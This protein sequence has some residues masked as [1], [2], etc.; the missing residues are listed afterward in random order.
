MDV[1]ILK[2][3]KPLVS[4]IIP[5]FN[6]KEIIKRAIESVIKQ[7]YENW[8]LIVVDDG[9]TD[10]T[11]DY[12]SKSI[13]VWQDNIEQISGYQKSIRTIQI[14]HRGVS[15]ARNFGIENSQGEWICFLD[16]DDEWL[17]EKLTCQI[18]FHSEHSDIEFSQTNEIWNKKGNLLSPKGKHK[19]MNGSY[20]KESL[21][22]CMVTNSS[23]MAKKKAWIEVGGYRNELLT[24][25]DY[26]V[27]NRI[28]I[29]GKEIGLIEKPLLIRYGGHQ[30]QLSLRY[31]AMERFRLYSLLKTREE[32]IMSGYW[33]DLSNAHRIL[34]EDAIESRFRI[35]IQG[36]EKRGKS[37]Q[38]LTKLQTL[39]HSGKK[40]TRLDLDPLISNE[41]SA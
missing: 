28:F 5:T 18:K 40:I 23:F 32:K 14:D 13:Q 22:I 4:I 8:E 17:S 7:T 15:Y 6:R 39:F 33:D 41:Y 31:P 20:L 3:W 24:C 10:D 19:K 11:M 36:K 9:S 1:R 38:S 16:S 34:W 37:T 30:D 2:D 35:L 29:S 26:D 27:W 12:L 21:E 25:E